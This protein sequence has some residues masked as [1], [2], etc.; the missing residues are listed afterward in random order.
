MVN[1]KGYTKNNHKIISTFTIHIIYP[2]EFQ[3]ECERGG[4][5]GVKKVYFTLS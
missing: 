5:E 1:K 4:G 2:V 3:R